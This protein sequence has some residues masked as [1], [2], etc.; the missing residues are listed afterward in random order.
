[1][2]GLN[3]SKL[4]AFARAVLVRTRQVMRIALFPLAVVAALPLLLVIALLAPFRK[5]RF[6]HIGKVNH[7]GWL[8]QCPEAYLREWER[9]GKPPRTTVVFLMSHPDNRPLFDVYRRH[10]PVIESALFNLYADFIAPV[11]KPLGLF[12]YDHHHYFDHKRYATTGPALSLNS[13]EQ[14]RGLA[15]L[16]AMGVDPHGWFVCFH[17]RDS[18]HYDCDVHEYRNSS[19]VRCIPAMKKVAERGGFAIRV[20]ATVAETLPET[21]NPRIIDYATKHR[22]P[23]MDIYLSTSNRFFFGTTAGL[24][25]VP[26]LFNCPVAM[27]NAVTLSIA[28]TPFRPSDPYVCKL[29]KD[30]TGRLVPFP[31]LY[32]MGMFARNFSSET[33]VEALNRYGIQ[34]VENTPEELVDLCEDMFDILEGRAPSAEGRRLQLL[35]RDR[36]LPPRPDKDFTPL[37]APRFALRHAALIEG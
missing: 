10:V 4:R 18:L 25:C 29:Y 3:V 21:G 5:L 24:V 8:A 7:I 19:I 36:F 35:Y 15:G 33:F 17:S 28:G 14:R 11:M 26:T 20:G 22:S 27:A 16:E 37:L 34:C 31:E 23:F 1:M 2:I 6:A 32:E 9:S 12:L 13:D 30:R